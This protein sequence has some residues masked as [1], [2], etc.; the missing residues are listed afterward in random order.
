ML[1]VLKPKEKD[2]NRMWLGAVRQQDREPT[3]M[4]LETRILRVPANAGS[5][6]RW[7]ASLNRHQVLHGE[8]VDVFV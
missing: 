1:N 3:L 4:P 2:N 7:S 5:S 8:T 6:A